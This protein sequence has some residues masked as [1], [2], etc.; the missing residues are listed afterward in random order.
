MTSETQG[1]SRK[2]D[3]R[4]PS[5]D[6]NQHKKIF[7][8]GSKTYYNSTR[9]FPEEIRR[10][11]YLLY[12]FV[13]VADNFV[14]EIPQNA[15]GFYAFCREYRE[16]WSKGP[17][18]ETGDP[19]IDGFIELQRRKKFNPAW[20]EAFLHSM[21]L[22]LKKSVYRTLDETLEY[23]Y[24]SAEVIGLF[25]SRIMD[26]PK[27][28]DHAA[29]MLG[30]AMQYINFI[31]DIDE[32]NSLG[33]QY[34]PAEYTELQDLSYESAKE[35]PREFSR[36]LRDEIGRYQKWQREAAAGYQYIPRQYRIPIK[37]AADM[38]AWTAKKIHQQPFIIY[39]KKVKPSKTRIVFRGILNKMGVTA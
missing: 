14:D 18:I 4:G 7:Q 24:G 31:R 1:S 9:F 28:A 25:M 12:A 20:T 26:L 23:I 22:D 34:L 2:L 39:K 36:F 35:D 33:R 5:G 17:G 16:T 8:T 11:V 32:D 10:D 19:V 30:R 27:E 13:R 15:D 38:Y 37:T 21:E 29:C 6:E 3:G